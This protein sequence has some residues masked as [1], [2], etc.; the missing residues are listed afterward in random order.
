MTEQ[1]LFDEKTRRKL[2]QLTLQASRIRA[3]AIKGE[4]RSIKR[5]TSIEFADTRNYSPGDDLRRLDWNAYGRLDRP[6]IKLYEDEEDLTVH[7]IVDTSASMDFPKDGI[8]EQHKFDYARRLMAGLGYTSLAT[9]DRLFITSVGA[10]TQRFG[11]ARGRAYSVR[12]LSF[13]AG[14]KARGATDLNAALRDYATHTKLPGL[15]LILTDMFSP[16]GYLEGINALLGKG[17]EVAVI[18][19]L[20]P[21]E[22]DP[23]IVGDLRLIDSETGAGQEVSMDAGLRDLYIRRVAAW[24]DEIRRE[25]SKRGAHYIAVTTDYA[26]E[27]VI[28]YDLRRLG[29]VK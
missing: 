26:W 15:C 23:T 22:V 14:L 12:L 17:H 10:E 24:R 18:H 9:N 4:R 13:A 7:V 29:L 1:P 27:K 28:L 8:P 25:I 19:I 21:E 5:G 3:G 16:S 11:P 2:E 6:L 20:A